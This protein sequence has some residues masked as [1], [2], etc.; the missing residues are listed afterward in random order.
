MDVNNA[1]LRRDLEEEVFM[2]L[3]PGFYSSK[4]NQVCRLSKSLYGLHQAPRQRFAKLS[5]KLLAYESVRS[6]AD[7][8]LFTYLKGDIS[9]PYL[10]MLT[11]SFWLV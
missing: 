10:S 9:W 3:A 5:S 6:Y 11:I 8:S 2:K 4:P 7:Y 1:F